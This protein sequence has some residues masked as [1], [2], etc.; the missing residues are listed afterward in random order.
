MNSKQSIRSKS[1]IV[2]F[3]HDAS[4]PNKE[5]LIG[6][7][8][9]RAG[10]FVKNLSPVQ[11]LGTSGY[12]TILKKLVEEI[13]WEVTD[14]DENGN[15]TALKRGGSEIHIE[16]DGRL[17]IVSKPRK[18]LFSLCREYEM[19]AR[20]IDEISKE[21]GIHWIS[22]GRQPFAKNT[23]IIFAFPEKIKACHNNYHKH[24]PDWHEKEFTMWEKKNNSVHVNF[25]YTSEKDAIDKFQTL[26]KVSPILMA[27]FANSPFSSGKFSGFLTKRNHSNSLCC[28]H[29]TQIQKIFFEENFSFEKWIDYLVKMP[30]RRIDREG[31][32]IF[33]P[34]LFNDF[35]T[36]GYKR[37]RACMKDFYL[38]GKYP[39]FKTGC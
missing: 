23:D 24:Y 15:I 18:G 7:E 17:E 32:Q 10:V 12:L 31:N 36:N 22:M 35:L 21:F 37:H 38:H 27:M 33:I 6:I 2:K 28:P 13:G 9:E 30:M 11:Y 8:V 19:H 26:L 1:D 14:Q 39:F 34:L 4:V 3:F 5:L 20:E 25:G 29:R 16:D